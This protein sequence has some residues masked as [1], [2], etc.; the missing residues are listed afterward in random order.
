MYLDATNLYGLW[1]SQPLPYDE[2]N[3]ERNAW[4]NETWNTPDGNDIEIFLKLD[5]SYPYYIRE[6]TKQFP[7][8]PENKIIYED[9]FIDYMNKIETKIIQNIEN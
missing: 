4:L 2:I 6:K 7:F 5:L 8:C 9:D 3:I 1:M